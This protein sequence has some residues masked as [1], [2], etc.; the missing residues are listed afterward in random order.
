MNKE[1]QTDQAVDTFQ[2]QHCSNHAFDLANNHHGHLNLA[3]EPSSKASSRKV[4]SVSSHIEESSVM[5]KS[6]MHKSNSEKMLNLNSQ[7]LYASHENE[8]SWWYDVCIR[9]N[10]PE[11][12]KKEY[13]PEIWRRVCPQPYCLSYRRVTRILALTLIGFLAWTILYAIVGDIA[14]PPKG[15]IFQLIILSI[16]SYFGGWLFGLTTLP[17]LVGMLFTGI[18]MQNLNIVNIDAS[19]SHLN[20]HLSAVALVIILTRAGL[21]LDPSA[22]NKL[23]FTVLKLSIIPWTTE[24][25]VTIVLSKF[26]LSIGWKYAILLGS[27]TAA[28]APAVV[29]P[30]LFRLRSKGYGVVKGIPTLIIA[31]ASIDDALSVAIFGVVL[32]IIFNGSSITEGVVFGSLSILA[33]MVIGVMWGMICNLT[34]ERND[35]FAAPLRI[36][37]LL[38]G[39][40]AG[41]FGSELIG[42]GGAGPLICVTAAFVSLVNWSKQGWHIE[43]NPAAI[44]FEIF[45]MI[46]QPILFGI[47]GSKIKLRELDG[48]IV[49]ISLG[50][51]L[52][53]VLLR[54]GVTILVGIGCNM[55]LKEKLFVSVSWISKGIVQAALGPIAL[56]LLEHKESSEKM[57]AEKLLQCCILSIILTAPTGALLTTVLGPIL[58]TKEK[59]HSPESATRRKSRRQSF[60]SP[61]LLVD[62]NNFEDGELGNNAAITAIVEE[63]GETY[64]SQ[65]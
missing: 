63:D 26:L 38:V 15:Q 3:F 40:L 29:V 13:Q 53:V 5:K 35:P 49:L 31:V 24:A 12:V 6:Q 9:L 61:D 18:A 28:V 23:K 57:D 7:D 17:A 34:P 30:C 62:K 43:E 55:N 45:W 39:G 21:D 1:L 46:F 2:S 36:L 42:Y 19:F 4:S 37:L 56:S 58:L 60:L 51:L 14:A 64:K 33:G 20:K 22:V 52:L 32:G 16:F 59:S 27:I 54:I 44:A 48:E 47:T 41:V 8:S 11:E 65:K 10:S 25:A 50:I